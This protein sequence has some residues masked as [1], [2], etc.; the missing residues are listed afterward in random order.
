MVLSTVIS[1]ISENNPGHKDFSRIF[2]SVYCRKFHKN[3][4]F[5]GNAVM[6]KF[7]SQFYEFLVTGALQISDLILLFIES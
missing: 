5:Q 2:Y 7:Y 3:Y 4:P 6:P 1:V